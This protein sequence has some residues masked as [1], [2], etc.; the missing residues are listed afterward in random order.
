M[1]LIRKKLG[2]AGLA[3]AAGIVW[4]TFAEPTYAAAFGSF[5]LVV[6]QVGDG[7]AALTNAAT[8]AS[9]QEYTIGG[10]L[11]QSLPLPTVASGA[12]L[13]LTVSGTS[14]SEGFLTLSPDGQY[15][16]IAGYNAAPGT[17]SITGSNAGTINRSVARIDM[18]GVIDTSTALTDNLT[19]GN[20]RSVVSDGNNIW[21]ATSSQGIRYTTFGTVGTSTQISSTPTNT[22]VVNIRNGQLYVSSASGTFQGPATVGTGEPTTT[23]QTTTLLNGFPTTSG[24]SPYDY[25]FADDNTLYVADDRATLSNGG[26]QKWTQSAGTWSLKY[27]LN[28]TATSGIRG[29]TGYDDGAGNF[30]LFGTTTESNANKIVSI[31]D[32]ISATTLPGNAFATVATAPTNTAFRGVELLA[33][34]PGSAMLLVIGAAGVLNGRRRRRA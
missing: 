22:R 17:A 14:T 24:P 8:A 28:V 13:A 15:L 23:G 29:L 4:F 31:S 32:L 3:L 10:S 19:L 33:P 18:S 34:E 1:H 12:N 16:T 2:C 27:T 9:L 25:L 20:P 11:V 7:T 26:I 6:T 5:N 30:V 21:V